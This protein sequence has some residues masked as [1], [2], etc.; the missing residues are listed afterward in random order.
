MNDEEREQR[1]SAE[2]QTTLRSV[3]AVVLLILFAVLVVASILV[4]LL[5]DDEL[6]TTLVL[7]LSASILGAMAAFLG[8]TLALRRGE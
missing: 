7:G 3:T 4:P 2:L 8:V 6:D 5:T 1:E